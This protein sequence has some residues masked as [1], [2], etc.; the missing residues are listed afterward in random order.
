MLQKLEL[1]SLL[2]YL[3]IVWKL[4][5]LMLYREKVSRLVRDKLIQIDQTIEKDADLCVV[6]P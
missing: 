4:C 1:K 3:R 6:Q 5:E 2:I